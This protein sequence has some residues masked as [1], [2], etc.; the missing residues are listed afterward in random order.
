[1]RMGNQN[2]K[3]GN[4]NDNKYGLYINNNIRSCMRIRGSLHNVIL[5][6]EPCRN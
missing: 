6:N 1:M 5:I 4:M 3:A 2:C